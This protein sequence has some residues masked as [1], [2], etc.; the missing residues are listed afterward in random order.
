MT[1]VGSLGTIASIKVYIYTKL[2]LAI[3]V[4]CFF[5]VVVFEC[6]IDLFAVL[7]LY[8]NSDGDLVKPC[9]FLLKFKQQ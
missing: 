9:T 4:E 3:C 7:S 5:R 1:I 8:F 2:K 6:F